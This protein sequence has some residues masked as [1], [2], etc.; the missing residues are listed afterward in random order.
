MDRRNLG[1]VIRN[2]CNLAWDIGAGHRF[3]G[4]DASQRRNLGEVIRN[5]CNLGDVMRTGCDSIVGVF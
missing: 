4:V 5:G 3:Q 1:D 2:G